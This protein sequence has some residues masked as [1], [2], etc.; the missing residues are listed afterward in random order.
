MKE[1]LH[2]PFREAPTLTNLI[3][4]H[5]RIASLSQQLYLYYMACCTYTD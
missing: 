4:R 2:V 3:L 5:F 1:I